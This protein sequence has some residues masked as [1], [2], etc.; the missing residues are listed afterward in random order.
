[1]EIILKDFNVLNNLKYLVPKFTN[2][3]AMLQ[4]NKTLM[5]TLDMFNSK[6]TVIK[7]LMT[8]LFT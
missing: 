2:N 1:M 5:K 7:K 4:N 3:Q 6:V 8:V